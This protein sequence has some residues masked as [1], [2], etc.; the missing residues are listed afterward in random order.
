MHEQG[1]QEH[2]L[3]FKTVGDFQLRLFSL[4]Y[5]K[6]LMNISC[7]QKFYVSLNFWSIT[8]FSVHISNN[9]VLQIKTTCVS[10]WITFQTVVFMQDWSQPCRP[11]IHFRARLA[12]FCSSISEEICFDLFLKKVL[13]LTDVKIFIVRSLITLHHA[14]SQG[15]NDIFYQFRLSQTSIGPVAPCLLN[16]FARSPVLTNIVFLSSLK[17]SN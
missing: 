15:M 7:V 13:I 17:A 5:F 11:Y 14:Q 2:F 12:F 1:F 9:V 8:F 10:C 3:S 16:F 6:P 4:P